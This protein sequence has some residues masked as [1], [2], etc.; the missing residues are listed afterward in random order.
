SLSLEKPDL[1]FLEA[2]N[3]EILRMSSSDSVCAKGLMMAFLRL[4]VL[5][6]TN[7]FCK[8]S[9][10]CCASLGL[11]AMAELPSALWHDAHAFSVK[12]ASPLTRSGLAL[13]ATAAAGLAGSPA[14]KL[15]L[16]VAPKRAASRK[17]T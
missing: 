1:A 2:M 14:A 8:Y 16:A 17:E 5:N 3:H 12:S 15:T 10:C 9:G 11:A 4:P 7:C 6:S 13:A